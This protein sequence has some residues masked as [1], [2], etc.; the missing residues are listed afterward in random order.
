MP[1]EKTNARYLKS[2][3]V[4]KP[5]K[6][7]LDAFLVERRYFSDLQQA[8]TAI[9]LGRV[10]DLRSGC[11]LDTPGLSVKP[12]LE[13]LIDELDRFVGRGGEKLESFLHFAKIKVAQY[14]SLYISGLYKWLL[15]RKL[16]T[17]P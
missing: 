12:D 17:F 6:M 15:T 8:T 16:L 3:H 1:S 9:R 10:R 4:I 5:R 11:A 2:G 13:I 7:R 14:R